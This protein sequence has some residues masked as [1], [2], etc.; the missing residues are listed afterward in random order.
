[1]DIHAAVINAE[2]RIKDQLTNCLMRTGF[3][4]VVAIIVY[5][6]NAFSL[7]CAWTEKRPFMQSA[8]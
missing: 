6:Y 2:D 3:N 8:Q 7:L 5:I 1:V 4:L